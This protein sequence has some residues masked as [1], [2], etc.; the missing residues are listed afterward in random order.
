MGDSSAVSDAR[1]RGKETNVVSNRE[2]T[3]DN[4]EKGAKDERKQWNRGEWDGQASSGNFCSWE[5]CEWTNQIFFV[6]FA[7]AEKLSSET[8]CTKPT[9]W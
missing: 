1:M 8:G 5:N 2:F 6:T 3:W 9:C 7:W 4:R